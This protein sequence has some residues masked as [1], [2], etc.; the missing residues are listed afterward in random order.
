MRGT[1]AAPASAEVDVVDAQ[2]ARLRFGA[3]L[4]PRVHGRDGAEDEPIEAL[5]HER[6]RLRVRAR[7]PLSLLPI[8][9]RPPG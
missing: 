7:E 1:L 9:L 5:Q 8:L 6:E 2:E 4:P 3:E